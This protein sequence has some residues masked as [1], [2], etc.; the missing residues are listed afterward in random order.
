MNNTDKFKRTYTFPAIVLLLIFSLVPPILTWITGADSVVSVFTDIPNLINIGNSVL[1]ALICASASVIIG[2][3][4]AYIV[5]K[6]KF[7]MKKFFKWIFAF[8]M[9]LPVSILAL[10]TK[11]I[12]QISG[13]EIHPLIPIGIV[14]VLSNAPLVIYFVGSRWVFLDKSCENCARTLGTRPVAVFLSITT[15][16]MRSETAFS[17]SLAFIRCFSDISAFRILGDGSKLVNTCTFTYNLWQSGN[18]DAAKALSLA[19]FIILFISLMIMFIDSWHGISRE[20]RLIK[21]K[22]FLPILLVSI[23]LLVSLIVF[24]FPFVVFIGKLLFANGSFAFS[25]PAVFSSAD[26]LG[27]KCVIY[28]AIIS[29][30]SALLCTF[31]A[32]RLSFA[33]ARN[34]FSTYLAFLP[35]AM[36]ASA[37]GMGFSYIGKLL[38][39]V[40]PIIFAILVTVV[41]MIPVAVM[42]LLSAILGITKDFSDVSRTLGFSSRASFRNIDSRLLRPN[43]FESFFVVAFLSF[44]EF[45]TLA[46]LNGNTVPTQIIALLESGD[47][48]GAYAL[49][50]LLLIVSIVFYSVA[51]CLNSKGTSN[52]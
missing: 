45:G 41:R 8:L 52:A 10:S 44:G 29:L 25:I 18:Q 38:P 33:I 37:L 6:L 21:V 23:Y 27:T 20:Q 14:L 32:K 26:A 13:L 47:T 43:V 11:Y 42:I 17:F 34:G 51:N 24:V 5:A 15:S 9:L 36:G 46:F 30:S 40:N 16:R 31:L 7:P 3:P 35:L 22:G 1:F 49:A 28:S 4:G 39:F 12:L 48:N 19:S 50:A 2:F